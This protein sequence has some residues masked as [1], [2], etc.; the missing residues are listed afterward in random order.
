MN[1][2]HFLR[3]CSLAFDMSNGNVD[4]A[5][6]WIVNANNNKTCSNTLT[7]MPAKN[8]TEQEVREGRRNGKIACIKMH[9]NRTGLSLKE[10]KDICEAHFRDVLREEFESHKIYGGVGVDLA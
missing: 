2:S 7:L 9:R 8:L 1:R 10:S 5:I 6:A 4:E 3:M